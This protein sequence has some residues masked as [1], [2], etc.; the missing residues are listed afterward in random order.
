MKK[1]AQIKTLTEMFDLCEDYF[2]DRMDRKD[3]EVDPIKR[4][5]KEGVFFFIPTLQQAP[6]KKRCYGMLQS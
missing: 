2:K 6:Q 4:P 5:F 3:Q 1:Y